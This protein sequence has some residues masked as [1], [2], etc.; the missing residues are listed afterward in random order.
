MFTRRH[1]STTAAALG[2][3][4]LGFAAP[5]TAQDVTLRLHEFL[6]E[7]AAVVQ[8]VLVAWMDKV[9]AESDGRIKIELY[10]SM[11][12]G[13]APPELVD[14]VQDGIADIIWT[15]PGYTPGRFPSL[16][17]MELPF[18]VTDAGQASRAL[19]QLAEDRDLFDGELAGMHVLALWVHGPGAIHADRPVTTPAD[20]AGMNIRAPTRTVTMLLGALGANPVGMPVPAVPEALQK[21]VIDGAMLPWEV[22]T[23]LHISDLV[24][25][26]TEF[27]G[28]FPYTAV[29]LLAMNQESYD[30]L[31]D[32]LKAVIDANSGLDMSGWAGMTQ[33]GLDAAGRQIAVEAG[34]T[35]VT[36]TGAGAEAWA[37]AA[38][39]VYA[40]WT[41][42][43]DDAGHD[44]TGLLAEARAL[45]ASEAGN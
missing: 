28:P 42:E 44:G 33:E 23:S 20:L 26:H 25:D 17:V 12:L 30:G 13:G 41:A 34:D 45:L 40:Q 4:T 8:S 38:E 5:A 24:D 6:P 27:D 19:W 3:A 9:E 15:L 21:G 7:G 18:F 14:Q 37:A 31:P 2:L 22:T 39:P 32:D 11:Q 35:I 16:E 10:P 36:I 29:F 1:F 43:L